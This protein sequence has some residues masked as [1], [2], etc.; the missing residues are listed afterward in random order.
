MHVI[1]NENFLLWS[2]ELTLKGSNLGTA[3]AGGILFLR[4]SPY[5]QFNLVER[6]RSGQWSQGENGYEMDVALSKY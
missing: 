4:I 3:Q 5:R 6:H 1:D 2:C